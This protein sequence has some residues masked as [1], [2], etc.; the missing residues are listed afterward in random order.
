MTAMPT[1]IW[2]DGRLVDAHAPHL[3]VSDRGFQLG[4]G[5]FE[6]ARARRG[7]VIELD[8]H[9]ERL[10]ESAASLALHLPVADEA[11]A[12]GIAE[13][14]DAEGLAGTGAAGAGIGD[15]ALRITVSR[16]P[17]EKRGLLPPGFEEVAAT[18]A[19]QAWPY[20]PPPDELLERGVRAIPSAVRR[21][22]GSP[23]A[24]VK[25]TSRADYVYAKLE[26][27]RAGADD[28]LFLTTDGAISEGTTANVYVAGRPDDRHAAQ[29]G[30]DPGRHHPHLAAR[31]R[32]VARAGDR[33]G[34]GPAGAPPGRRRGVPELQRGRDRAAH[35]VRRSA[36]RLRAPGSEDPRDPGRPRG[37]DRRDEPRRARRGT[38]TVTGR[39][40]TDPTDELIRRTRQLVDEGDRLVA[41]PSLGALQVWLQRSDDLLSAAWGTMD[42]YHLSWLMVGKPKG[43]VRGRPMTPDE[44]AAYVREVATQKTA[45]LRMSLDAV[46]RD[47]MP[48]VGEDGGVGTTR[49]PGDRPMTA[50]VPAVG[51]ERDVPAPDPFARDYLL[52]ALRLDAR[53]PG[54]VD[55]YY[56]PAELKADGGPGAAP[57]PV[58]AGGRRRRPPGSPRG[59]SRPTRPAATGCGSRSSPSRP[60]PGRWPARRC[61]TWST[62][63]A[64]STSSRSAAPRPSSRPPPR[65][66]TAMCP[67]RV[68]SVT[69]W[70]PG[71]IGSSSRPTVC[72]RSSTGSSPASA[73]E[74]PPRSGC[75]MARTSGSRS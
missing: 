48:F 37:L 42:R 56:G 13:L 30:R 14:L 7:V 59:R 60:T 26:A 51:G 53:I 9:L 4:D 36:D 31:P 15:A 64:A 49:R 61:P 35:R 46:E 1:R 29:V 63:S 40:A 32:G 67:G 25:S 27:A 16:G 65:R 39:R 5:I 57:R 71:T 62:S 44:E 28:A 55:G 74:R 10:R 54:L 38:G 43:I 50:M 8:E 33:R 72:R 41:D 21:D 24:G 58:A 22:P 66:S 69:G 12:D 20:A 18:I 6:T 52:L 47:G 75:R 34:R 11:L 3:N 45:A 23:L 17:I 19:I 70:P 2:L 73:S 68:T